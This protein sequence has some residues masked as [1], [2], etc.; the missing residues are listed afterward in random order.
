MLGG[1]PSLLS[2]TDVFLALH[3]G[4]FFKAQ[5]VGKSIVKVEDNP[6]SAV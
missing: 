3:Y 6:K 1:V 2:G 5:L 4:R